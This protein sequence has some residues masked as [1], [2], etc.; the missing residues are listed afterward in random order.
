MSATYRFFATFP[1]E[2]SKEHLNTYVVPI[3]S[4][5]GFSRNIHTYM[6][7]KE[8]NICSSYLFYLEGPHELLDEVRGD[9]G[10]D[11]G[12][13]RVH[14]VRQ[15]HEQGHASKLNIIRF[16][17]YMLCFTMFYYMYMFIQFSKEY[18]TTSTLDFWRCKILY[19]YELHL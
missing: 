18:E 12:D 4:I 14:L 19:L 17:E 10:L 1:M 6:Y 2:P 7:V 3:S 11:P 8:L 15:D 16:E 5:S 13:P 9:D